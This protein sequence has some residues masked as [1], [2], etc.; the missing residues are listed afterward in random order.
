MS[1][2]DDTEA[3]EADNDDTD[4]DEDGPEEDVEEEAGGGDVHAEGC[5][6]EVDEGDELAE[7]GDKPVEGCGGDWEGFHTELDGGQENDDPPKPKRRKTKSGGGG[8]STMRERL[9]SQTAALKEKTAEVRETKKELK[10]VEKKFKR[11]VRLH[12]GHDISKAFR[13]SHGKMK[14]A[15]RNECDPL[16]SHLAQSQSNRPQQPS[17]ESH[18][19]SHSCYRKSYSG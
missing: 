11:W 13:K 6:E 9:K 4:S 7:G 12:Q 5:E 1:L 2:P 18:T 8:S 17:E 19:V 3:T 16:V 15:G 10:D 14:Q